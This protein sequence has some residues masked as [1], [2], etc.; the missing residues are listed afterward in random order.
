MS[1]PVYVSHPETTLQKMLWERHGFMSGFRF[2]GQEGFYPALAYALLLHYFVSYPGIWRFMQETYHTIISPLISIDTSFAH[3]Y[4][5]NQRF[6]IPDYWSQLSSACKDLC[7]SQFP[8]KENIQSRI[9]SGQMLSFEDI[10]HM[11]T[12]TA[13]F[14]IS[15]AIHRWIDNGPKTH[16]Y[17]KANTGQVMLFVNLVYENNHVV[18][19]IHESFTSQ[20]EISEPVFPHYMLYERKGHTALIL[21]PE[22]TDPVQEIDKKDTLIKAMAMMVSLLAKQVASM[23]TLPKELA[24]TSS[25][26]YELQRQV[27]PLLAE[28]MPESEFDTEALN[29]A[30]RVPVGESESVRVPHS[31]ATCAEYK[32]MQEMSVTDHGHFFHISCLQTHFSQL[33]SFDDLLRCPIPTCPNHLP[34]QV[35]DYL[36]AFKQLYSTW[37]QQHVVY[38]TTSKVSRA[39]PTCDYCQSVFPANQLCT[40]DQHRLCR[41]CCLLSWNSCHCVACSQLLSEEAKYN[42]TTFVRLQPASSSMH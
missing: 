20:R 16:H 6:S 25:T 38:H 17:C 21:A 14:H 13:Y 37:K 41:N 8:G 36:P 23:Q 33:V 3:Q 15:L 42:I 31:C 39:N 1:D 19:L 30:L 26:L 10:A 24:G 34:E 12:L 18:S 7:L 27:T 9:Q 11:S 5:D 22:H 40:V 2:R 4:P 28:L 35:L 29:R 32:E